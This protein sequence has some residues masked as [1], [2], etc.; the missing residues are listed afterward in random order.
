MKKENSEENALH[1]ANK[2]QNTTTGNE[3]KRKCEKEE[4][5]IIIM[6]A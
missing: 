6:G 1:F 5:K 4:K 3:V 2:I